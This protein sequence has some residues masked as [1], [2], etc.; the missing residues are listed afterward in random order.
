MIL[1]CLSIH[2]SQDSYFG[3]DFVPYAYARQGSSPLTSRPQTDLLLTRLSLALHRSEMAEAPPAA[4]PHTFG[5]F[6]DPLPFGSSSV[7]L[8]I[9]FP[10][11]THAYGLPERTVAHAL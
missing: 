6:T 2:L 9:S 1:N 5:K 11:A 3:G 7:G 4:E 8:D 10:H